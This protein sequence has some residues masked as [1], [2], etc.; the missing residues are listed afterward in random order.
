[1]PVSSVPLP[2]LKP[3]EA[4]AHKGDFGH[5]LLVGGGPGMTAA[6]VAPAGPA[7]IFMNSTKFYTIILM[8]FA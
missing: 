7:L 5:A 3:R 8:S 6:K 4:H 2:F 1:M